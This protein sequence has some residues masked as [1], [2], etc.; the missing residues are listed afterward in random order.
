MGVFF[1]ASIGG[2]LG[3]LLAIACL[4]LIAQGQS[5]KDTTLVISG[6]GTPPSWIFRC[7]ASSVAP[8]TPTRE[9]GEIELHLE[10]NPCEEFEFN[11]VWIR[12]LIEAVKE[13]AK[14]EKKQE[15]RG[16][17]IRG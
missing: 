2:I 13:G 15:S 9:P 12:Q 6:G 8:P 10:A 1:R 16:A 14:E 3:A 17:Y 4:A 5:K 11:P 7:R